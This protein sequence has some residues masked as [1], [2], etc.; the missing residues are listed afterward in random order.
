MENTLYIYIGKV[1]DFLNNNIL[2]TF[3]LKEILN[4]KN[5]DIINQKKAVYGLLAKAV[6]DIYGF[7]DDFRHI[8]KTQNGKPISSRY[9]FSLSHT[10][11]IVSVAIFNENIGLDIEKIDNTKKIKNINNLIIHED[12]KINQNIEEITKIWVK[13]EAIFKMLGDKKF[14]PN[15]INSNNYIVQ[16]NSFNYNNEKYCLAVASENL[17]NIKIINLLN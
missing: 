15:Q 17:H 7:K 3:A 2:P 10:K 16:E 14:I 13:K 1:D 4:N 6:N 11:E 5:Q 9:F 12:E 8:S